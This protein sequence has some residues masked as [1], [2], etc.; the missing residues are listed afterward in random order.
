MNFIFEKLCHGQINIKGYCKKC[1]EGKCKGKLMIVWSED[2]FV[3]T[4]N[5]LPLYRARALELLLEQVG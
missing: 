3:G 4:W 2:L 1:W 5:V